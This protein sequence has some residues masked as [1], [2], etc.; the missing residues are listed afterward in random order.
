MSLQ[1]FLGSSGSGKS[2]GLYRE[3]ISQ[4]KLNPQTNF[5]VIVPEQ[6]TLQTQKDIVSLHPDHGVMNV[7]IL[8][9]L[10][11]AFRIFDEVG[12]N[13]Y[14][15][16]EDTGKSMVIRKVVAEKK[17]DLILF[18]SNVNKSGFI[19]ELKSLLS[20]MFQYNIEK[21]DFNKMLEIAQE[22]PILKAKIKDLFTVYEGFQAFMKERY[23]TAEEVLNLLNQVIDKSQ[24]LKDSVICLDGYTGFTPSQY[25]VLENMMKYSKKVMVTL[26]IDP[27]ESIDKEESYEHQLFGL[28]KKTIHKLY[29][30]AEENN[31]EI[32]DPIYAEGFQK[33]PVPYR[34]KNSPSLAHLER[35][36]FR[37][38]YEIYEMEPKEISIHATVDIKEEVAFVTREIKRLVRE[39]HYRYRDIAVVTGDIEQYGE[40]IKRKFIEAKIPCFIDYK[41]DIL[42]N[43]FVELLRSALSVV[44]EDFNYESVFRYLRTGLTGLSTEEIDL[45]ENYCLAT[46]IRGYKRWQESFTRRYKSRETIDLEKI[47]EIRAHFMEEID[48]LYQVL[49]SKEK[50]IQDYITALYDLGIRLDIEKKLLEYQQLFDEKNQPS[51]KKEYEQIYRIVMEIYDQI[52]LLLGAENCSLKEFTDILETGF[53]EAKVG[54]IPPGVDEVVVGDTQRTRLKDIRT[55]F[56]VGVNEGIVPASMGTGGILSDMDRE[57]LV[58]HDIELAPTKRQQA[59]TEQFYIYLN[60]TKPKERLYISFHKVNGEGKSINPSFLVGKLLQIFKGLKIQNEDEEKEDAEYILRD[61]GMTYLSEGLRKLY[62]KEFS[63]FWRELFVYYKASE[64]KSPV[65]HQML[66]G[67][68]Y[69]NKEHGISKE[70]ARLLYG[71]ELRGSITRLE[72]YAG[73]AFAHFL[74]YGLAL[75]ERQ[76]YKLAIPDIGNIFHN[77]LDEFSKRL[78][79]GPYNWHTIPDDLRDQWAMECVEAAVEAYE[80]SF[81]RSTK[82]NEYMIARMQRITV[83]TLWALCNQIRQGAFEPIGY[84]LP[85]YHVPDVSLTLTGRIDR[86]DIYEDEEKVYVRVVDYK[87][88]NTFF[89]IG[90]IYYGLQQQLSVYLSAAMEFLKKEKQD[91]EIVP[92]GIFYYHIDDPLVAKSPQSEEEIYKS[93]KMNGLVN[94]DKKV[95]SL[96][97]QKIAG[98]DGSLRASVKSDIIPV[99]INKDG[100]PNKRSSVAEEKEIYG[101]LEY[102]N[103]KLFEDGKQVL[104]GDTKLSPYRLKNRTACDYCEYR[105]VCGFDSRLP[106]FAYRNLGGK[107]IEEMKEEIWGRRGQV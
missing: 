40:I 46:G 14:P 100:E 28:S 31:I 11:F 91:K 10:R 106:G 90:S 65:L 84:E 7:D 79:T 69:V 96:M 32:L 35:N 54:L 99:E 73:C 71:R 98:P 86:L 82:R 77:A 50:T 63:D 18:G 30:I 64:E 13:E 74:S 24:W 49:K 5:L 33:S 1:L 48:P 80:N 47:N 58:E 70:A 107:S 23:I 93:L 68:F 36:L 15:V 29:K 59:F 25:R 76:E 20:E 57:L 83:R 78:D 19:N 62:D 2:Y 12:G 103:K 72:R 42:N 95:L 55:L 4:S 51:K 60:M 6:F 61:E 17:K 97:D 85:F 26:T 101:L 102:V 22:K 53:M 16:L 9:F 81:L 34:F 56:F 41:K 3:V 44:S 66:Q 21:Q 43:P 37:Y 87:S 52:V 39:E 8:S 27:R 94:K 105:T 89:D 104:E 45:L 67:A 88:G 38:P 92:A 75:E